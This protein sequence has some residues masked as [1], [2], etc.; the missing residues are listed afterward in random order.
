MLQLLTFWGK[1]LTLGTSRYQLNASIRTPSKKYFYWF[2]ERWRD[3]WYCQISFSS[4]W[5]NFDEL[6]Y[7]PKQQNLAFCLWPRFAR[8]AQHTPT[9]TSVLP[10]SC[11]WLLGVLC[12]HSQA[13]KI[14]TTLD[15]LVQPPQPLRIKFS[16]TT[17]LSRYYPCSSIYRD[18]TNAPLPVIIHILQFS[19]D[20]NTISSNQKGGLFVVRL[21]Y[22]HEQTP[23]ENNHYVDR[24]SIHSK[25]GFSC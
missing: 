20:A 5:L 18:N 24:H 2:R 6:Q 22:R 9:A 23:F 7:H 4:T 25:C 10:Q 15:H 11:L 16:D 21:W 14:H 19:P 17:V 13:Q 3:I 1:I 12:W 8:N